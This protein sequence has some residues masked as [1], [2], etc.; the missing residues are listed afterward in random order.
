MAGKAVIRTDGKDGA[1]R[2]R[3]G[4][5]AIRN[6]V[7][8]RARRVGQDDAGRDPAG[9]G[10]CAE[11]GR[12]RPSRAPRSATSTRPSSA[13][14]GRSGWRWRRCSHDGVK[15]NLLDTP[16]YAD[17]VGELRAGLRAAD[18]AMFVIAANEGVDEPTRALWRECAEVGDAAGG[19]GHQARPRPRRL[20]RRRCAQ[21]QEAFGDKVLPVVPAA[22]GGRGCVG[23]H[24]RATDVRDRRRAA[25]RADRG[26]HRGVRGRDA[27]G[28]L[29]R[30]RG[31]RRRRCWSRTSS[32][33]SRAAR[34]SRSFPVRRHAPASA[35][36]SCSTW[37]CAGFPSPARAPAARGV[38]PAAASRARRCA[39]DPDGP[40]GRRGGEDDHATR[41][42][43][44]SAWSGCSPAPSGPTR[45][46]TCRATSRRSSAPAPATGHADHDEDERIGALSF[47]LG[48]QQR[49][50]DRGGRRR[51]LRD[52]PAEPRRDR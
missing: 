42:S 31:D 11:P 30:R 28:A 40:A 13:S 26:G 47:P 48:K 6:V 35:P 17:F 12:H 36:S 14:S 3:T 22:S 34:S 10:R 51:H 29:P 45:R 50:A 20:R 2:S 52:R 46:C 15:V 25:R 39:C 33:R 27:D 44:G 16:G 18:C 37:S 21:A 9:R 38:H 23:L 4:P 5:T 32:R 8:G 7:A 19:G 1:P 49:P 24:H 43:A 41:T